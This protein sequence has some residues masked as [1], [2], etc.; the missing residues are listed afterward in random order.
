MQQVMKRT[1]I[2]KNMCLA[3]MLRLR[4]VSCHQTQKTHKATKT[5]Q[6]RISA[7]SFRSMWARV[8]V[9]TCQRVLAS[10]FSLG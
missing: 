9:N 6:L 5:T 8:A 1:C 7:H 3:E 10:V 4:S 2:E